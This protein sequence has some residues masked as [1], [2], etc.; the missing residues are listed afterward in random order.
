MIPTLSDQEKQ[1]ARLEAMVAALSKRVSY[2][3]R[4]NRRT[5]TAIQQ[6]AQRKG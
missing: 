5:Q 4:E 3:E 1:I 6:L 2:L